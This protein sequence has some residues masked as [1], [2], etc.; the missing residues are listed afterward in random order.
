[1]AK[2]R[3]Q[4]SEKKEELDIKIPEFDEH[5]YIALELRKSKMSFLAFFFAILMV[6]VTYLLYSIT[7]PD[8]RGP[9]V[10]GILGVV[11]L[12]VVTKL[13]KMDVSDFDWKNW[14]GSGAI[15][16]FS[17]LAI[18]ILVLNPP[19]S[20]FADPEI[21]LKEFSYLEPDKE[22][23][24]WTIPDLD[25][26]PT[27]GPLIESPLKIKVRA[28]ITDNSKIEKSSV[29]LIITPPILP[30]STETTF[31]MQYVKDNTYEKIIDLGNL[32][33]NTDVEQYKFTIEAKD[34]HDHKTILE[35]K[36]RVWYP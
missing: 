21:E 5:E 14:F 30:N 13:L 23:D 24:N 17:W 18:F 29:K 12:P 6:I 2:K 26:S 27:Q 33:Q 11:G 10:L 32:N 22:A 20:D 19:F 34:N 9:V 16:F 36:F 28:K 35:Q 15:Y 8:W 1:V 3:R 7:H 31:T 4:K 25:D